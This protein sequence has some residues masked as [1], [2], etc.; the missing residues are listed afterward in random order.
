MNEALIEKFYAY[1]LTEK[2]VSHNTFVAYKSDIG[3]F[4][5]FLKEQSFELKTLQSKDI[6]LFLRKLKQKKCSARTMTRKISSIKAFFNYLH[7]YEGIE[8]SGKSITFPR[9][10]KTLPQYLS[11][12]EVELLL[13]V[14]TCD[15]SPQAIRNK[16]M[17]YLLYATG[18]RISELVHIKVNDIHFDTGFLAVSGKGGKARMIPLPAV[19]IT[20]LKDYLS[21]TRQ[22]FM[23]KDQSE[24]VFMS[25]YKSR[26]RAMTRQAFW[27]ILKNLWKKTNIKQSI[28]PH[29][30][31]HSFATHM[32]K[33]GAH[34]RSLQLLLGHENLSTVQIYTHVE[35]SHLRQI[36][37]K[38]HPRS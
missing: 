37:D 11:E 8:N 35:T 27:V 2:R 22:H 18:I 13:Q 15:G 19:I 7:E 10:E 12:Q 16:V 36:Y 29:T 25:Y 9:L 1:L 5:A 3:Q 32:L 30:L 38:K 23:R 14:A 17:L 6:P 26:S 34:L 24:Y 20:L 28:S 4:A 21:S 33:N 31:R